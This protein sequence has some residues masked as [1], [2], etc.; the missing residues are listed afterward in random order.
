MLR[1]TARGL[2][3]LFCT[4]AFC[5]SLLAQTD[6]TITLRMLDGKTGRPILASGFLIRVDHDQTI[7]AN[8]VVPNEDGTAKLT[9]P[10][11]ANVV[12]IQG[13]YDDSTQIYFNCDS[14]NG[15]DNPIDRWYEI[16]DILTSGI[17]APNGCGKP[18]NAAKIKP[19]AKPGEFV[20]LVRKMTTAEQWR[21]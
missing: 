16:S 5:G 13:T 20:F 15:K 1:R 9:V 7:H 6:R 4:V 12:S 19:V 8:W 17:V 11:G 3:L 10:K 14:A 21:N 2:T 18:S